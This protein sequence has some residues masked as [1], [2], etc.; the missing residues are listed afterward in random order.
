[1]DKG[2]N[3]SSSST[4][5]QLKGQEGEG[6]ETVMGSQPGGNPKGSVGGCVL[7]NPGPAIHFWD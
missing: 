5:G 4:W 6:Q 2:L 1:M 3:H 7:L